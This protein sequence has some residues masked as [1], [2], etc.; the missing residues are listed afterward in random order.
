[1]LQSAQ[2]GLI[3]DNSF[4]QKKFHADTTKS[5]V[6]EVSVTWNFLTEL[7]RN[8]MDLSWQFTS[9]TYKVLQK[10]SS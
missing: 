9:T 10:H 4:S 6:T 1:M 7:E 5:A 8:G 2:I 3:D